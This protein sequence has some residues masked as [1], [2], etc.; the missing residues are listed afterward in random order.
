MSKAR[1]LANA[2][3]ALTTVSATELGYLDGVT[4]AVQTQINAKQATVSG[5]NDTEIG[6]LD[7]VTSAIQTQINAQI[8]KST[9]TAKG[10]LLVGTGSG[11]IVRQ[12]VGTDGQ[13]LVADSAQADGVNWATPSAG[14]MTLISTTTLTG[15][16]VT[17]SSIPSG[18]NHLYLLV[19]G[20]NP[21]T[22][23]NLSFRINGVSTVSTYRNDTSNDVIAN[24]FG[25]AAIP[26]SNNNIPSGQTLNSFS[27]F[28]WDY[29]NSNNWK[30]TTADNFFQS[31]VTTTESLYHRRWGLHNQTTAITSLVIFLSSGTFSAGTALL[32]GVK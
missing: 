23:A 2:G 21:S 17:L 1:D 13:V 19:K 11:T 4:S 25:Q 16:S 9:I 10:D 14:G 7:G 28:F 18:Y 8:P 3:T 15:A 31:T 27:T 22:N 5:V 32:Y 12:G 6:Y 29:S 24:S 30:L 26:M 20:V